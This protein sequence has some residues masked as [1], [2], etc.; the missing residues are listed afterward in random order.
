VVFERSDVARY[1]PSNHFFGLNV[2]EGSDVA[3]YAVRKL[4]FGLNRIALF[5]K[6]RM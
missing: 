4:F 3:R 6:T 5:F 1:V 2:F